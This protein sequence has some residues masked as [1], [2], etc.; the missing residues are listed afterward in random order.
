MAASAYAFVTTGKAAPRG[1]QRPGYWRDEFPG[2]D[3]QQ[4]RGYGT[5]HLVLSYPLG[6]N[7]QYHAY[8]PLNIHEISSPRP[9]T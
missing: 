5:D 7:S 1:R 6:A 3:Y 9:W 2:A 4:R 8:R